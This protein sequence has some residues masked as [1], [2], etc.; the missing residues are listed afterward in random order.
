MSKSTTRAL[1]STFLSRCID[2][3]VALKAYES[4]LATQ[5]RSLVPAAWESGAVDCLVTAYRGSPDLLQALLREPETVET[6]GYIVG[7]G[8]DQGLAAAMGVDLATALDPVSSLSARER[9][10]YDLLCEGLSNR[11]IAKRLFISVETVKVHA[12]HVYD[13]VEVRSRTALALQAARRRSMQR[14]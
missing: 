9:D 14:P 8:A 12:R 11:E 4:T 10:V 6:V 7:R 13:K 2:A 3:V 5:V 1:E